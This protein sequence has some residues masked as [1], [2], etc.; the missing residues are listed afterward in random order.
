MRVTDGT[1]HDA[2]TD[3]YCCILSPDLQHRLWIRGFCVCDVG[4]LSLALQRR[5]PAGD[6][7]SELTPLL[8]VRQQ[9][10]VGKSQQMGGIVAN[11]LRPR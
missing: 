4:A 9:G 1:S 5:N 7:I 11:N 10:S 3:A 8:C 2:A 6:I